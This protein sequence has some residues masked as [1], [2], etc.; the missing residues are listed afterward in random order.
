MTDPKW[1]RFEKLVHEIHKQWAPEG[2]QVTFDDQIVGCKSGTPRQIDISI[3]VAVAH[4]PVLIAVDCKDQAR[5]VDVIEVG[6]FA[7]LLEDVKAS[8]GVLISTSGFTAP[9]IKMA[10]ALA[11][12]TRTYLDTESVDWKTE[13]TIP[14]ILTRVALDAWAVSFSNVPGYPWAIPTNVPFPFIETYNPE[15]EPLGPIVALLGRVWNHSEDLHMPGEHEVAIAEHVLVDAGGRRAHTR[16]VA[17]L[18][19]ER[20][21]YRGPLRISLAGGFRNEQDGSL[22]AKGLQTDFIEPARI[23]RGE[24]PGWEEVESI[25]NHVIDRIVTAGDVGE[26]IPPTDLHPDAVPM[27]A[28][29][30][31]HYIDALPES[32]AEL[33]GVPRIISGIDARG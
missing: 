16:I 13:V 2:A 29:L 10:Q 6:A 22:L 9:A 31:L 24:M 19:V 3:R 33:S 4:Y 25:R 15:G 23:E 14:V 17:K 1:R 27:S 7:S 8:K 12:E 11:I 20:R 32:S 5:P 26:T 30:I 21:Y 18:K 28:M